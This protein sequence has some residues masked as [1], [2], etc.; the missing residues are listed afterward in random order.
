MADRRRVSRREFLEQAAIGAGALALGPYSALA[1]HQGLP[2]P[3]HSGIDHVI[4]V[5]MENRSFDHMIDWTAC[6]RYFCAIMGP[7]F[8]NRLYQ[9]AAQTDRLSNTPVLS[10]LPTIWTALPRRG[11][12]AA[13]TSATSRS[14]RCGD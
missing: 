9:H 14:W 2:D 4:L 11:S 1:K 13:T 10:T 7:T 12:R 8:P 5:M 3:S 6:D